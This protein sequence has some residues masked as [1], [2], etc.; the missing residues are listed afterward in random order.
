MIQ[1]SGLIFFV[2]AGLFTI[3]IASGCSYQKINDWHDYGLCDNVKSVKEISYE[4]ITTEPHQIR[5][6]TRKRMIPEFDYLVFFDEKGKTLEK[7]EFRAKERPEEPLIK[8]YSN[9]LDTIDDI[10]KKYVYEYDKGKRSKE[11]IYLP[12]TSGTFILREE[13]VYNYNF[14]GDLIEIVNYSYEN[15]YGISQLAKIV[16]FTYDTKDTIMK[17]VWADTYDNI[18]LEMTYKYEGSDRR[19]REKTMKSYSQSDFMMKT[20]YYYDEKE[21]LVKMIY[22]YLL[23]NESERSF[24]PY[25]DDT[26]VVF[27][28]EYKYDEKG[29]WVRQTIFKDGIPSYVNEREIDYYE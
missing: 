8:N 2:V 4:L 17:E 16:S 20:T 11:L 7:L 28:Y 13:N 26:D 6:G 19:I 15:L 18:L 21:Y 29:N 27:E 22:S 23:I 1:K 3:L 24:Y 14:K 12:S 25:F 10:C 9:K 5:K